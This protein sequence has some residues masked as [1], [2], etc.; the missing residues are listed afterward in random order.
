MVPATGA[1]PISKSSE[2]AYIKIDI[3]FVRDLASNT[4]NQHLVKAMVNIAHALGQRTIAEGVETVETLDLLREFGVDYAQGFHIGRP[5]PL[6]PA[7]RRARDLRREDGDLKSLA[8]GT[9][10]ATKDR[11]ATA[12][13]APSGSG[14]PGTAG[15]VA[16]A[17]EAALR[18]RAPGVHASTPMVRQL[19]VKVGRELGL[20][21]QDQALLD[22]AARVRDVGMVAV[23]D[24]VVMATKSLSPSDWEVVNRHPVIGAELLE[25]LFV[26]ASVAP[27][28]RAHHERWDGGG[29]PDG[30]AGDA[31]PLLSRVIAACDVFVAIASDR[32]HRRGVGAEAALEHVCLE[33]GSQLDPRTVDALVAAL[34]GDDEPGPS[35]RGAAAADLVTRGGPAPRRARG[36]R[37]DLTSA[38]EEFDVVPAFAPAHERVRAAAEA[39]AP[40]SAGQLVV[41][42]ESDTGLTVAVLR[43]AQT[44]AGRGQVANVADAVAALGPTGIQEAI[45]ALPRTEFPWRT[46]PFEVL[47]HR[48]RV[49]SQAVM[50]AADRIV[51]EAKVHE[52]DD[53]L[54]A[55]LLHDLGKLVLGRALPEYPSA[56]ERTATPEKRIR[57]EQRAF[58]MDHASVGGLLLRRW[59]LPRRLADT[60]AA[61]HTSEAENEVASYVR[62]ADMIVHH[63]QGDAVDRGKMLLLAH[64]CGLSATALRDVLFDLPHAGGSQRRRAERS[65]LSDRET[66]VL[67]LLAE[68]KLYKVIALELGLAT[69]TIRSHLHNVYAKLGVDDRAQAVLLATEMG[70]I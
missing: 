68:G 33:R 49:H 4:T 59:G 19:A 50:R 20:D 60:V 23:P 70:W 47:M 34:A 30:L 41:T 66:A 61:H 67:R 64:L 12:A 13:G 28:V 46:S 8:E 11:S 38:I 17:L 6:E 10:T 14:D 29:Y 53:V 5:Q 40:G 32:P 16:A 54:G 36:G 27:I 24:A 42:I 26:V 58:G 31:I 45:K 57:D 55:A 56:A 62:L 51:W 48:S 63:A 1:S 35:A 44:V 43:R 52:R 9:D 25:E 7:R 15:W 18:A 3:A 21:P 22:I 37:A 69:S 39:T 65:P 2:I